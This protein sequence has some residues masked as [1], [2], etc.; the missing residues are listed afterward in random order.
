SD[1]RASPTLPAHARPSPT[2]PTQPHTLQPLAARLPPAV[3]FG[4]LRMVTHAR[5]GSIIQIAVS[6][7]SAEPAMHFFVRKK[8]INGRILSGATHPALS[9][10]FTLTRTITR[11]LAALAIVATF[12]LAPALAQT[13]QTFGELVGKVTDDQGG[14]LPGVTVTLTGPAAMGSPTAVSNEQG[15]YRFPAVNSG[16]YTLKFE[17]AGFAPL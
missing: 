3:R 15:R 8:L 1:P 10:R 6:T 9:R 13:G 5:A 7:F 14:V 17:L 11:A 4:Q 12:G 2:P 16:T